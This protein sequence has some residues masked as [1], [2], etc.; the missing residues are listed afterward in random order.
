VNVRLVQGKPVLLTFT[1]SLLDDFDNGVGQLNV[2][3]NGQ[4]VVDVPAGLNHLTGTGDF[5]AY[6]TIT[7]F[8]PFDITSFI[9]TGQNTILFKDPTIFDH[10][11]VVSNIVVTQDGSVLLNAPRA[12]GVYPAFSF[13][14]TFSNPALTVTS[15]VP[16]DSAN[17]IVSAATVDQR[18]SFTAM[19][20]G[21][22]GPFSCVF[23]FGD[24]HRAVVA[25][26]NGVCS[27]THAFD[28][29]GTFDVTVTV[30]GASTSDVVRGHFSVGVTGDPNSTVLTS[31]V[32][33]NDT[34][35]SIS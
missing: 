4:L 18:L 34:L 29:A 16:L 26:T 17:N 8:G 33:T 23:A 19:Y 21:G 12:R 32:Q 9:V 3:V 28:S 5:D 11:G 35:S 10:F 15:F 6:D 14:Y 24:G 13:S 31:L 20:T 7:N 2:L 30:R 22:T 27:A 1:G 25:G